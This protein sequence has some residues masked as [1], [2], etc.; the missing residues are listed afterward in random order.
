MW[1]KSILNR[2][3]PVNRYDERMGIMRLIL[4]AVF[5]ILWSQVAV[6]VSVPF[7]FSFIIV[8]AVA[9]AGPVIVFAILKLLRVK[10]P[11][12]WGEFLFM[13]AAAVLAILPVG[14]FF[15]K[16]YLSIYRAMGVS[17]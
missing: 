1:S 14:E 11:L 16:S 3:S 13:F 17:F 10:L 9:L 4:L 6:F 7:S 15:S 8:W 2:L 12:S 5:G